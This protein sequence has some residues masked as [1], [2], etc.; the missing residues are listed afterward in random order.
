MNGYLLPITCPACGHDVEPVAGGKPALTEV[1]ASC[2][3]SNPGCHRAYL[4]T[5]LLRATP[6]QE[7]QR[8]MSYRNRE[9]QPA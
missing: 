7:S 2:R 9:R 4:V 3:C 8:R 1:R 5:V 6:S